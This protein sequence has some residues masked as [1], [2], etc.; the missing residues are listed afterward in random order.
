MKGFL[1]MATIH[2]VAREAGV[3]TATVSRV[4]Q[5]SPKVI[6]ETRER[7]NE[8]IQRL[9]YRP[10]KL[11]QQFRVQKTYNI[12]VIVPEIGNTFYA[13]ILAG[14]EAV[15][16]QHNYSVLVVDTHGDA[17]LESHFFSMLR[18]KQVDG[19]IT[20]SAGL[21]AEEMKLYAEEFPIVIACRHFDDASLPNVSID[22]LKASKD[23]TNYLLNLGHK[24][25][26]CLAGL[27]NLRIYRDRL[28]GF[29]SSLADRGISID[30]NLIVNCDPSIQGGY[31]AV[32]SLL[33]SGLKFSA[34]V[35]NGDT[36]AVGAIRA[37]NDH[38]YTVPGDFAVVGFDDIQLSSLFSPT[39][40]TVRQ[41]KNLIGT[42][43]AEKLL[44]LIEGKKLATVREI[45][46]YELII[47]ESSGEY[48]GNKF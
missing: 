38:H 22:N 46:N 7:V 6:P 24:K 28:H 35:A 48:V 3:S 17:K 11:A 39:I 33:N 14:I 15:A 32:C 30:K 31:D 9:A 27:P 5:G 47:R 25:I 21:P 37:L 23:I 29:L 41:P 2:D 1:P 20:F 10:N 18:E 36:M 34:V 4:L 42:R 13:D 40:T 43:A 12:L 26:C 16:F 44:D 45:L 19:I 8:A